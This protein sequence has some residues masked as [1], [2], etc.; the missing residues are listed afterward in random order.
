MRRKQ[1]YVRHFYRQLTVVK[2]FSRDITKTVLTLHASVIAKENKVRFDEE[3]SPIFKLFTILLDIPK[4][5]IAIV[6]GETRR[7][8]A[9]SSYNYGM[10]GDVVETMEGL[11]PIDSFTKKCI[12]PGGTVL[13]MA[14]I[15][16]KNK[17]GARNW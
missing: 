8:K 5:Q 17:N 4:V 1:G 13:S 9:K 3:E 14:E 2:I 15:N 6:S 7:W 11:T 12:T 16:K 10:R